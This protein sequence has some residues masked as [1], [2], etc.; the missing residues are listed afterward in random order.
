[1]AIQRNQINC[2]ISKKKKK[3]IVMSRCLKKSFCVT[4]NV[5]MQPSRKAPQ[6]ARLHE[7]AVFLRITPKAALT[8]PSTI[9][10]PIGDRQ[11]LI[12]RT[13]EGKSHLRSFS[14]RRPPVQFQVF[15]AK[16]LR[17]DVKMMFSGEGRCHIAERM[18]E[19]YVKTTVG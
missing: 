14:A 4:S 1:M 7:K 10:L 2:C 18:L 8:S 16:C 19:F 15:R 5:F 13:L 17:C 11:G 12:G 3:K 9:L 6:N